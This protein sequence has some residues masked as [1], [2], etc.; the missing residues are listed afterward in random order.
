MANGN[1]DTAQ[2][3]AVYVPGTT[4]NL[5]GAGGDIN[6][7][8]ELWRQASSEA[9]DVSVSTITWLGYDAPQNIVTDS[10]FEHYAYDGAPAYRQFMD[11]L[12]TSHGGPGEPHRTAIGHSYGTTLIGAAAETGDL[13]ADDVILAGS[14][15]V[16][17]G[18][19]EEMDVPK[20]H[21]WNEEAEGDAVPEI[22][23]W[24]HGGSQWKLGGGTFLLP[25]DKEFG[26]NQMN[27]HPEGSGPDATTGS[28]GHSEYWNRGTT[29]LKNQALVVI[30]RHGNVTA[31]P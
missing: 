22:G 18:S 14:P 15:G 12:G 10:P 29:A 27:T 7:M 2:H 30:G 23:R 21:V 5:G 31:A 11:G 16:K 4:S 28:E 3:Q 13:R 26:A 24:G 9:P 19:A 6:R 1:P 25:S 20:G 8:T 17:V